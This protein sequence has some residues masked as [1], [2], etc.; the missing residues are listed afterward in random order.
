MG[1]LGPQVEA[2]SNR[3]FGGVPNEKSNHRGSEPQFL[4]DKYA[5]KRA[6]E[7]RTKEVLKILREGDPKKI[8][9]LKQQHET[10]E[11]EKYPQAAV[12]PIVSAKHQEKPTDK[13]KGCINL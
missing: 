3:H 9:E 6:E 10:A 11:R 1:K 2:E 5:H 12:Q 13:G 4:I 7:A 8:A